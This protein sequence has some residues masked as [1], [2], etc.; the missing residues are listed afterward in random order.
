[1]INRLYTTEINKLMKQFPVVAILGPRQCGKTTLANLYKKNSKK[2]ALYFDLESPVDAQK[3][4][5]PQLVLTELENECV[6]IDEVQ[7][8]PQL[9][10]LLRHLVDKK[11]K[12]GRFLVLGSASPDMIKNVSETLAGR[13][14]YVDAHPFNLTEIDI[15]PTTL[16]KHW[17]RGGFPDF[18]I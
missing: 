9:F 10:A 17:F 5:D 1:M 18:L 14:A 3:L 12:P 15:K 7:R 4:Y 6:I 16:Y 13:I 8:M 2:N 11:R